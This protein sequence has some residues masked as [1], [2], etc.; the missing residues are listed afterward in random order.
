MV[1]VYCHEIIPIKLAK[2]R[3]T[4]QTQA[5]KLSSPNIV[6]WITLVLQAAMHDNTC[7]VLPNREIHTSLGVQKFYWGQTW[8]N[9]WLILVTESPA[10]PEDKLILCGPR[11]SP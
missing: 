7:E 11:L 2:K 8:S 5:S 4:E 10:A 9:Q 3:V 1:K 6:T